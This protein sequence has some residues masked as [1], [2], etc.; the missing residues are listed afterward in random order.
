MPASTIIYIYEREVR[1]EIIPSLF[2]AIAILKLI[3]RG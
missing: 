2:Y 1:G 3:M